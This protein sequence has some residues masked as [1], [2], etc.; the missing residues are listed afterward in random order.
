MRRYPHWSKNAVEHIKGKMDVFEA[1][2][3]TKS[4][5]EP[6]FTKARGWLGIVTFI[7][8]T[9]AWRPL[10]H[11]SLFVPLGRRIRPSD[12]SLKIGASE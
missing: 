1:R 10:T 11:V 3:V 9:I 7:D 5:A 8:I 6:T 4:R 2:S 12:E